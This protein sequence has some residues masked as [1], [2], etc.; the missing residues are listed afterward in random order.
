LPMLYILRVT[1]RRH[2]A[3]LWIPSSTDAA[4]DAEPRTAILLGDQDRQPP[5]S[6]QRLTNSVG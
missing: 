3:G 5:P 1:R 2:A 6:S 4:R